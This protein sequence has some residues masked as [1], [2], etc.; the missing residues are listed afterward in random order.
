MVQTAPMGYE[1]HVVVTLQ[2]PPSEA[3][4]K[5]LDHHFGEATHEH[6]TKTVQLSEHVSMPSE[7]DAIGFVQALVLDTIPQGAKITSI[8]A[9]PA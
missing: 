2:K 5:E 7:A 9:T 3:L 4:M 6:G 8:S 1:V